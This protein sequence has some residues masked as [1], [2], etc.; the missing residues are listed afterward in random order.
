M[1]LPVDGGEM[2]LELGVPELVHRTRL[3]ENL[4]VEGVL[5]YPHEPHP[6]CRRNKRP[7]SA[8]ISAPTGPSCANMSPNAR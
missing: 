4:A 2:V 3:A 5:A 6:P 1:L 7:A 8:S